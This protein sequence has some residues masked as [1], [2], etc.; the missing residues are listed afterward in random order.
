MIVPEEILSKWGV[1]IQAAKDYYIDSKPTGLS[2]A[3]YDDLE[4]RAF[5]ED[6][7]E[8]RAWVFYTFLPKGSRSEN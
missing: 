5:S 8:V 1:L 4:K 7:L 3:E 2:D 6:G